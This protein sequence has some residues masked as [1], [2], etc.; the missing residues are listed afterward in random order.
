MFLDLSSNE[1]DA[2]E[3]TAL[4]KNTSRTNLATLNLSENYIHAERASAVLQVGLKLQL[5][6][7]KKANQ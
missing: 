5:N 2:E 7:E 3:A 6:F 4:S 1:I